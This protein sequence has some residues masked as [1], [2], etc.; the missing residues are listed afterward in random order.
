MLHEE[1]PRPAPRQEGAFVSTET[2]RLIHSL[3]QN[4]AQ[5]I[6]G[7]PD[8]NPFRDLAFPAIPFYAGRPWFLPLVGLWYKVADWLR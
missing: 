8:R 5:A 1:V 4:I 2:G 3:E 7:K 6:L